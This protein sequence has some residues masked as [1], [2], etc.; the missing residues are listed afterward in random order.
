MLP[1]MSQVLCDDDGWECFALCFYFAL[2]VRIWGGK[3]TLRLTEDSHLRR[4]AVL[5]WIP[6]LA[7][8]LHI[9]LIIHTT[10]GQW[11]SLCSRVNPLPEDS[12]TNRMNHLKFSGIMRIWKFIYS[13]LGWIAFPGSCCRSQHCLK[14]VPY[15]K[16]AIPQV[17]FLKLRFAPFA[18][19][20]Q[21][22]PEQW[23][24]FKH[25]W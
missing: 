22:L 9:A 7:A 2:R 5:K 14:V 13:P 25:F 8:L 20:S 17:N 4:L 15:K 6:V 16:I 21:L 11:S 19:M 18:S 24:P 12:F 3:I 1:S 10:L 23:A